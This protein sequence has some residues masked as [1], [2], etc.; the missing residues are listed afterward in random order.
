MVSR[1]QIVKAELFSIVTCFVRALKPLLNICSK[2]TNILV[3]ADQLVYYVFFL[4]L[5]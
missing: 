2:R 5:E 4:L 3:H 1:I